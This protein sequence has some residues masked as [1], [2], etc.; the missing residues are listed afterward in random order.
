MFVGMAGGLV[1]A[2]PGGGCRGCRVF[3][4]DEMPG[5]TCQ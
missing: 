1:G 4:G 2:R 3:G 5:S